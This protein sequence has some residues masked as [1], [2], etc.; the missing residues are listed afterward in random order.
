MFPV[1]LNNTYNEH[2]CA[3]KKIEPGRLH[4]SKE[5][6]ENKRSIEHNIRIL[7]ICDKT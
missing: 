5:L 6:L 7:Q 1:I 4:F 2:I 3:W